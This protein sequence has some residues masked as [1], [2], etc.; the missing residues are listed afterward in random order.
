M[1]YLIVKASTL[2]KSKK[3]KKYLKY[4]IIEAPCKEAVPEEYTDRQGQKHLRFFINK[5]TVDGIYY[6]SQKYECDIA[7][8]RK[9]D[10]ILPLHITLIMLD[11][12]LIED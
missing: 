1:K 3:D 4:E 6:L 8:S 7:I 12:P 2:N 10:E 11:E 9:K 5:N